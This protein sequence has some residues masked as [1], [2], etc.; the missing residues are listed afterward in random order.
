MFG[1]QRMGDDLRSH[2]FL[3]WHLSK[4]GKGEAPSTGGESVSESPSEIAP[5]NPTF[6]KARKV[7]HP[8]VV[9]GLDGDHLMATVTV[10][11]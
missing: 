4:N 11:R 10:V 2:P 9:Y 5:W 1:V 6:R 8:S 3:Y 7:G